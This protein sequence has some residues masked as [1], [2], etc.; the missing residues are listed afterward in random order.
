MASSPT[1]KIDRKVRK[2]CQVLLRDSRRALRRYEYRIPKNVKVLLKERVDALGAAFDKD[3]GD[4]MRIELTRLDELTDEHLGFARK[5]TVREYVESIGIAVMIALFLRAFVVEAFKIPSGS[6][7]PT[8]EI[9]DHIFVN[10]F[11]YGVRI[12]YTRTKFFQFRDPKRGEV[13][14]FINPCE[15]EKDFIKRIVALEGDKVEVRCDELYINDKHVPSTLDDHEQCKYWDYTESDRTWQRKTC[16]LY[17]QN[18]GGNS[19]NAQFDS[20]RPDTDAM[21]DKNGPYFTTP[22][23]FP[24]LRQP[25]VQDGLT[26][27]VTLSVGDKQT[28]YLK[29]SQP[30]CLVGLRSPE[31]QAKANTTFGVSARQGSAACTPRYHYVVPKGHVFVMGDN[32]SNSSDSRVWGPVPK[33]NIKGKALIIWWSKKSYDPGW[34]KG[35]EWDR[36]G[37][38]VD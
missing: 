5:S 22:T 30:T 15:P 12:P 23:D 2:E 3:D 1:S 10:K 17:K 11:I 13:V 7:V 9:G 25:T 24:E 26:P 29:P 14:V 4:T 16:S 36:L 38:V 27:T 19:F 28:T 20:D 6:M 31:A 37:R 33:E 34:L 32:R 35:I 18:I 21:R 8:M